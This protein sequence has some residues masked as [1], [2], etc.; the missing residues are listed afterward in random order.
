MSDSTL[1]NDVSVKEFSDA[2]TDQNVLQIQIIVGAL[3][4]GVLTFLSIAFYLNLTGEK[5]LVPIA[6]DGVLYVII[7]STFTLFS[8]VLSAILPRLATVMPA[9]ELRGQPF[10]PAQRAFQQ[11]QVLTILRFAPLEGA[12]LAGCVFFFIGQGY[13]CLLAT[14]PI[15]VIGYLKFP[16]RQRIINQ[17]IV[18]VKK[19][20]RLLHTAL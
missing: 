10:P 9:T 3:L 17:F 13:I 16:T 11:V 14:L 6:E 7:A 20:P 1:P 19:D 4:I 15:F 12:A 8:L 5:V 18:D 2:L